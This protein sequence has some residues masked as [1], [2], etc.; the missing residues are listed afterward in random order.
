MRKESGFSYVIVMFLVA[1]LSIVSVRALEITLTR[2]KRDKEA[3]LLEI[4]TAYLRAIE[5]YYN[6]APGTA[7]S[8]PAELSALLYDERLTRPQ[9]PLRKLFRDPITG[10]AT[11]GVIRNPAGAVIGVHSL[12]DAKPFKQKGFPIELQSFNGAQRYSDWKFIYQPP[13]QG[14]Q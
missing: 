14:Q 7:R 5:Q 4:G 6:E 11:W 12:S 10:S 2:E 8:Y 3:Q 9:R 13:I 1:V